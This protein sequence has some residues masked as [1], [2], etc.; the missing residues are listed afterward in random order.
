[1]AIWCACPAGGEGLAAVRPLRLACVSLRLMTIAP[2]PAPPRLLE[3]R[4]AAPEIDG[5]GALRARPWRL[6]VTACLAVAT[7]SLLFPSVPTYDPWAWLIWGREILHGD[8]V[9]TT[10]PSWKPLPVLF[11]TPFALLGDAGAPL[12]WLVV[13]RAGGLLAVA[14]AYRLG[15]RLAGPV[16]GLVAAGALALAD[17]FIF[18]FFRGNSEGILVAVCLWAVERHLDGRRVDAFLLGV[19]AA[20]LRPEMWPILFLYGCVL[21]RE[22]R[23]RRTVTTVLGGGALVIAL[24]FIPEYVGSGDFLRAASRARDANPDSLAFAARPFVAVLQQSYGVLTFPIYVGALIAVAVAIRARDRVVLAMAVAAAGLMVAVAVMTQVGFAGNL[25]YVALPAAV[26]CVLAGVGWVR[27]GL[28]AWRWRG[29]APLVAVVVVAPI[30]AAP[31]VRADLDALELDAMTIKDEALI[32]GA[33]P[34]VIAAAG[35]EDRLKDCRPVYTGAFQTMT[36][37]WYLHLHQSEVEIHPFP[38]GTAIAPDFEPLSRDGRFPM[39]AQT[40]RWIV[41]STC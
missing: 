7:A 27:L 41:G 8:L 19:V 31:Y 39:L 29:L 30:F 36:V 33:V 24:W 23:S 5:R 25:R 34:K 1:V 26:V 22:D 40:D 38:M 2:A 21:L 28:L 32:Y 17:E 35:G 37:A 16:A 4:P 10:G 11:T 12:A 20:L 6:L 13:A 9:T 15:R 14:M 18:N 3:W